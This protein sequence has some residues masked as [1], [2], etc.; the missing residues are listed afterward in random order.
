MMDKFLRNIFWFIS[1]S[2]EVRSFGIRVRI[3]K[4]VKSE[5]GFLKLEEIKESRGDLDAPGDNF[6]NLTF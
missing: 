2:S 5:S 4:R 3:D 1:P 6:P